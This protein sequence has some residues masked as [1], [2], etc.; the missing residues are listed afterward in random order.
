MKINV[1]NVLWLVFA[2]MIG[3]SSCK[4]DEE[5]PAPTIT[6][7]TNSISTNQMG[8]SAP[9]GT[10]VTINLTA[11]AS[12]GIAKLNATKTVSG[13]ENTLSNY[14]KTD[15]FT[16][17]TEHT[18]NASYTISETSGTVVLKFSVEDKK[19][20]IESKTFT[21][22]VESDYSIWTARL[23]AAPLLDQS[24]KT[25][26]ISST[27]GTHN[28][29]EAKANSSLVDFGYFEGATGMA[30]L[31]A[32]SDYLTAPQGYDLDWITKNPTE[33]KRT[34]NVNF[35]T[36]SSA[37]DIGTEY[38]AGTLATNGSNPVGG[39][40]RVNMLQVD[41]VVGFKTVAGKKGLLKVTAIVPGIGSSGSITFDVKV[42][43]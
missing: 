24:S 17:S 6:I 25:F 21:I 4:K 18:W 8:G 41:D 33:F 3:L 19:G 30:T 35:S 2:G 43:K 28:L 14:P 20:K 26:F 37:S 42:Q 31:A 1:K 34:T 7:N 39:S 10:T 9:S 22:T 36:I 23:L 38:D 40:T 11:K 27:G 5:T 16:S 32:P 13:V 29:A 12:E 15:N